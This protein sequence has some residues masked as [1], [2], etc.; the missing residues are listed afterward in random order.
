MKC[1]VN[2]EFIQITE[3][4]GEVILDINIEEN[5]IILKKDLSKYAESRILTLTPELEERNIL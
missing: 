1:T 2:A 4:D 3:D 5:S